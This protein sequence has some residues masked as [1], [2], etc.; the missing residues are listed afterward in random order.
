MTTSLFDR[1]IITFGL[2]ALVACGT[3]YAIAY[4]CV[5]F[6]DTQ[7]KKNM[8]NWEMG[9][10]FIVGLCFFIGAV[11]DH[12]N[13][14]DEDWYKEMYEPWFWFL[15]VGIILLIAGYLYKTNK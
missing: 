1:W 11:L 12:L 15:L 7:N 13:N 9:L 2:F 5:N 6:P 8:L 10:A 4:N 3:C 14:E